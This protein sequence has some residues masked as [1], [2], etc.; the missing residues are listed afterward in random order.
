MKFTEHYN[1]YFDTDIAENSDWE[2]KEGVNNE[3]WT[4]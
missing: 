3:M 1:M 4:V 2:Q